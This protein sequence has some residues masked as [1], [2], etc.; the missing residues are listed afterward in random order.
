MF[1]KVIRIMLFV[2]VVCA[3]CNASGQVSYARKG[4]NKPNVQN[5]QKS[6]GEESDLPEK[7]KPNSELKE[8]NEDGGVNTSLRVLLCRICVPYGHNLQFKSV[9]IPK[10]S[11]LTQSEL[12]LPLSFTCNPPPTLSLRGGGLLRLG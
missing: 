7:W 2:F 9:H 11:D 5:T 4:G 3:F 6:N 1:K 8:F 10:R 12:E